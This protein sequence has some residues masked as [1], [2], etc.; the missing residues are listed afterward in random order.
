MVRRL[1][2]YLMI[3]ALPV[4]AD[5]KGSVRGRVSDP[6]G[7]MIP[8]AAVTLHDLADG[9]TF[10]TVTDQQGQY[11]FD[12]IEAGP[13]RVSASADGFRSV[14]QDTIVISGQRVELN[15]RLA[16]SD[17]AIA[18]ITVTDS[19]GQIELRSTSIQ[20][21]LTTTDVTHLAGASESVAGIEARTNTACSQEHLHI[22]GGHQVGYQVNGITIPDLS[23]F[24]TLTP[25]IDPRNLKFA[26]VTTGGLLPEFGNRTA[27]VVNAITR[28][29][30]DRG[31]HG[32]VETSGGNLG[33]ESLF[34]N[35][36]DHI[37][38]RL[39][40]YIQGTAGAA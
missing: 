36:G 1:I 11:Q 3:C 24:G 4:L 13:Y 37:S 8:G 16:L 29:G 9:Q 39:A 2:F 18:E 21:T 15:F 38:D 22:R 30:F 6:T 32:R 5:S 7:A 10:N 23:L 34:A 26:E 31:E 14:G 35:F 19:A 12:F 28:S 33:R 17:A 40:Y 27:G 20:S 25:V